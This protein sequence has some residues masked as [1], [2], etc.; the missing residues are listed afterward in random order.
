MPLVQPLILEPSPAIDRVSAYWR[1]ACCLSG[2]RPAGGPIQALATLA[3]GGTVTR[4]GLPLPWPDAVYYWPITGG[5]VVV[6]IN[7][8]TSIAQYALGVLLATPVNSPPFSPRVHPFFAAAALQVRAVLF[9]ALLSLGGGTVFYMGHSLGGAVAQLLAGITQPWS[10]AGAWS[11]GQPR[12]GT[13]S[14]VTAQTAPAERWTNQGDVVPLL[15]PSV[16]PLVD[17]SFLPFW[18]PQP[19]SYLH[20]G[21]RIHVWPS[22][23]ISDPAEMVSWDEGTAYL[24]TVLSGPGG[25][26]RAHDTDIYL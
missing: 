2:Y 19:L 26:T 21:R 23:E 22:G 25:W 13:A 18:T 8:T 15:P 16:N 9:P 20:R 1:A 6:L 17:L 24:L 5:G 11:M 4:L 12:V 14:W 10:V 7:G 3:G